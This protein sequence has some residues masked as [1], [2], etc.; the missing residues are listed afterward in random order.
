MSD[1]PAPATSGLPSI[2]VVI[3]AYTLDRWEQI[4][5]AVLSVVAQSRPPVELFICVDHNAELLARA[6]D[7]LPPLAGGAFPVHVVE[8]R[9][10]SHLGGARTTAAEL[11]MGDVLAFLDDDAAATPGWLARLAADYDD[12]GVMA[13]GGAPV[14]RYEIDR[15]RWIP[16]ECNWVFGCA[17]RGLPETKGPVEHLIGANMSIR[18]A[19][20]LSWGGFQSDNHDDMDLSHRT[21]HAHGP[22]SV[23]YDPEAVVHHFVPR[24][25]LT[26]TYFWRRCFFVNRGK[27]AAFRGLGDASN[28]RAE[29]G[30]ARRSLTRGLGYEGRA[31][32]HGDPYAPVRYAVLVAALFLGATG[33]VVGRLRRP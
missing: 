1:V 15:P 22:S 16:H 28:L 14:A 11:A 31:L 5:E 3:C 33:A 24:G 8:N 12:P 17:Y 2:S 20:L 32:L 9:F 23:I 6:R 4:I 21:A 7:V 29:I 30:F 27:V 10:A 19:V 25:R 26:W 18:R 13:V